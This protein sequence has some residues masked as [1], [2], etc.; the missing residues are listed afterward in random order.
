MG[1]RL[2][3][4]H[5]AIFIGVLCV[6]RDGSAW[7]QD[8][9]KVK[10]STRTAARLAWPMCLLS[11]TLTALGL[12]LLILNLS[13]PKVEIFDYWIEVTVMAV[14][15]STVGGVIASR[16]PENLTGWLCCAIGLV[17]GIRL[18]SAE[19]AAHSLLA[20]PR[21]LPGGEVMAW[22]LSWIWLLHLGL[23]V[24]LGLLFPSGL[25]PYKRWR[26]FALFSAAVF[27]VGSI[28]LAFSPGPVVG[29]SSIQNPLGVET[30]SGIESLVKML[31]YT[32]GLVTAVSMLERLRYARGVE[33]QQLKWVTYAGAVLASGGILLYLI[34]PAISIQWLFW[35]SFV[36]FMVGLVG[37][38]LALGIAILRYRLYDIDHIINRT[39]VYGVLTATLAAIYFGGVAVTEA[40]VRTL[41]GQEEQPQLAIV[42]STLV[43]A[44]LFNPLRRRIQ[45]VID[46]R[47]YRR[48][49]DAAKTLEAFSAKLRDET[50]LDS[51]SEDLVQ[52]V[53]ETMQ[54]AHVSLWLRPDSAGKGEGSGSSP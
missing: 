46:Q 23:F 50:D 27:A 40:L 4:Y 32:C 20:A 5:S 53:R 49:Y 26:R 51:V 21:S 12:L 17:G 10:M 41:T 43:I 14:A 11:L 31:G 47:F 39:L 9:G 42:V 25:L 3:V 7:N 38:P 18:F 45:V 34:W 8:T 30:L 52:V 13:K 16:R 15:F 33:H 22:I 54:P 6:R 29:F 44:A 24:F 28:S 48:K 37:V 1:T 19:Y 36:V 2:A 35:T